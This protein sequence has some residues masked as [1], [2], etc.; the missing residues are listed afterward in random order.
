MLPERDIAIG[1]ELEAAVLGALLETPGRV[2]ELPAGFNADA[3]STDIARRVF[4]A[5]ERAARAKTPPDL[6]AIAAD[7]RLDRVDD[8]R[9]LAGGS[10]GPEL[11]TLAV[12]LLGRRRRESLR[13]SLVSAAQALQ[14]DAA[15]EEVVGDLTS[16]LLALDTV[17]RPEVV[18]YREA[19]LAAMDAIEAEKQGRGNALVTGFPD[20]DAKVRVRPG[21]VVVLAAR[22]AV[23]KST[24]ALNIASF[25]ARNTGHVLFHSLEMSREELVLRDIA[26]GGRVRLDRL[27]APTWL[28]GEPDALMYE[29]D[30]RAE[31]RLL[32]NDS[33][34][35]LGPIQRITEKLHRKHGLRLVVVDYLQLVESGIKGASREAQVSAVSRGLKVLAQRLGI[36]VIAVSQLNRESVK[37]EVA[38]PRSRK[39]DPPPPP[40]RVP[41]PK[42]HDLRESGAIEQD[43]NTVLFLHHPL[44]ESPVAIER[45][46]GPYEVIVAKQRMGKTGVV[47]LMAQ[48]EYARF[49]SVQNSSVSYVGGEA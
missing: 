14:G 34:Y 9:D 20:L 25:V 35:G 41:A 3:F 15:T 1:I 32:I 31:S 33:H 44:A 48:L 21:N 12:Q 8:L 42:L 4:P 27:M 26:S 11:G 13:A 49:A 39:G 47:R 30:R 5:L 28:E 36:P 38:K 40:P 6:R 7:A 19:A 2:F 23:G 29:V 45:E 22:P 10:V 18:T 17:G 16:K 37:R 24:L 43:A 46:R